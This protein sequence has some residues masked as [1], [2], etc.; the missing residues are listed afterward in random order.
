MMS[1]IRL[2]VDHY[3]GG[4]N[5]ECMSRRIELLHQAKALVWKKS[6]VI[7]ENPKP[8]PPPANLLQHPLI[9]LVE[10]ALSKKGKKFTH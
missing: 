3:V 5:V 2:E 7:G 1:N 10:R 6:K 4:F 8:P 9:Q